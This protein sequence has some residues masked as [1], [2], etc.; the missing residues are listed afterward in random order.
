MTGVKP[1]LAVFGV[2][3]SGLSGGIT[4]SGIQQGNVVFAW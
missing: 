4:V 2:S 1:G 3:V